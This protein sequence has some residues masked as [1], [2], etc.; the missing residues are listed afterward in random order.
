MKVVW[1]D[2]ILQTQKLLQVARGDNNNINAQFDCSFK[3]TTLW[4]H[5]PF[6]SAHLKY[7][8]WP[9]SL[10]MCGGQMWISQGAQRFSNWTIYDGVSMQPVCGEAFII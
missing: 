5:K 7:L 1:E 2:K 10:S 6:G 3:H 8:G 4:L 9:L